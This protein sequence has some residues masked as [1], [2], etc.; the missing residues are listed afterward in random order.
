[1]LW[2][3]KM[4]L[5]YLSKKEQKSYYGEKAGTRAII[6]E[7]LDRMNLY[8]LKKVEDCI[9]GLGFDVRNKLYETPAFK[10]VKKEK[11]NGNKLVWSK[12]HH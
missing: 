5:K 1:M 2:E 10:A 12:A 11:N 3:F 7:C 4:N 6:D 9:G 8:D